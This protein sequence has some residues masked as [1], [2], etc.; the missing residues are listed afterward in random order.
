MTILQLQLRKRLSE[1][2]LSVR[3]LEAKAGLSFGI[4]Q[5]LMTGE[6]K[7]PGAKIL[8][9]LSQALE[10]SV[11]ELLTGNPSISPSPSSSSKPQHPWNAQLYRD[12]QKSVEFSLEK[13]DLSLS[14]EK[15]VEIIWAIYTFSLSKTPPCIDPLF[16]D[17]LFTR[18]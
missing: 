4:V 18:D 3:A 9:N 7:N 15:I 11:D 17:W 16:V 2:N 8:I 13:Q 1:K 6:R 14:A 12:A 10:C 5:K